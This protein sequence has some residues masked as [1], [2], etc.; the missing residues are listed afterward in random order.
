MIVTRVLGNLRVPTKRSKDI[1]QQAKGITLIKSTQI[2]W[3]SRWSGGGGWSCRAE[4][5]QR[6]RVSKLRA[7]GLS[8]YH[9]SEILLKAARQGASGPNKRATLTTYL[10]K[11]VEL[12]S[13]SLLDGERAKGSPPEKSTM[14]KKERL[15]TLNSRCCCR[16][17]GWWWWGCRWMRSKHV[18]HS[19]KVITLTWWT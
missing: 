18:I 10:L 6:P 4:V 8:D 12:K 1:L 17:E 15:L 9:S 2:R 5:H 7:K 11:K 19:Q 3:F 14:N 16:R 13:S